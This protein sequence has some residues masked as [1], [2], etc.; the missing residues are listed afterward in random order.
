MP[1]CSAVPGMSSTSS[2]TA[3]S[4]SCA[5]DVGWQGAKPTPQLPI[6]T[7][8][9]PWLDAGISRESQVACPSRCVCTSTQPGRDQPAGGIDL[10]PPAA[11]DATDRGDA[12]ALHRDIARE[13]R[14]ARAVDDAAVADHQ[15]VF[16]GP[17][18]LS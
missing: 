18:L 7:V 10:A 9:T 5:S 15:V 12:P 17:A 3:I 13:R 11:R 14:R 8:V 4:A 6:T 1:S 16:H 2:I